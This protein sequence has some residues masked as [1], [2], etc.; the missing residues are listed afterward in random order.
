MYSCKVNLIWHAYEPDRPTNAILVIASE[1]SER[2]NP[3]FKGLLL[4]AL[5]SIKLDIS[6]KFFRTTFEVM[7][8]H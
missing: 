6:R 1:R 7:W 4:N 3:L 5:L 2:I 8:I